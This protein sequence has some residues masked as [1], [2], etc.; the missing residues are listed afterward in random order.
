MARCRPGETSDCVQPRRVRWLARYAR[1][2]AGRA[3]SPHGRAVPQA[4]GSSYPRGSFTKP[5]SRGGKPMPMSPRRSTSAN[6]TRS[7][8][9]SLTRRSAAMY[10]AKTTATS[11]SR[12]VCRS[13]S[14]WNFPLAILTGMA[15][16]ALVGGNTVILK[17]AE[18]SSIVGAKL[19]ECLQA[20][21]VP[22]GVANFLPGDGEEIGPM[23]VT[24]PDV[25]AHRLHR[26]AE[27]GGLPSTSKRRRHRAVRTS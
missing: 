11:T 15:T 5:E 27:G 12:A 23:L 10:P 1:E 18:Q 4:A 17:P 19:M 8:W 6:T 9:R 7:K 21:G 14:P 26:L 2:R 25:A 24:H 16:A 3:T 22:P 13:S 20:A